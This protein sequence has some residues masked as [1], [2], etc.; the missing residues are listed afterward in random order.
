VSRVL[1]FDMDGVLVD[2]TES[3]REAIVQTVESFTGVAPGRELI[4][5]FKNRGGWN[6]D[7]KLSHR[8]VADAGLEIDYETVVK[9]FNELFMGRDHD[10]L[11]VR[12][13]WIARDGLLDRL[14]ERW[15][16]AIFTGRHRY[17]LDSSLGRLGMNGR[18]DPIFTHETSRRP[19]PAPDGLI[20]IAACCGA[21]ELWY[22][23]DTVDDADAARA[24]GVPFVGIAAAN[25][26]LRDCLLAAGAAAVIDDINHLESV[27][28]R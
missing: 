2:V 28:P 17:E 27:L 18:F 4:Q 25:P 15:R 9:R 19:K 21:T 14:A 3:Y 13:R 1:V 22:A 24:A 26:T 10:G 6:N 8:L 12:E 23:G 11:I 7:W 20:D 16:L 5:D